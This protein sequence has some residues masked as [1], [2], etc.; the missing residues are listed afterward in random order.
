M[1]TGC[2]RCPSERGVATALLLILTLPALALAQSEPPPGMEPVELTDPLD[3][4]TFE[5]FVPMSTNGLG[6][7]D[8]DGCSYARG[9][10]P[11]NHEIVTSPT[12]LYSA[13]LDAWKLPV[14]AEQK[15]PLMETLLSL[16]RDVESVRSLTPADK[17]E[18]AAAVARQLGRDEFTIGQL[19]LSGAWTV[20]DTIVGFLPGIQGAGDAW[21]KLVETLP[22]VKELTEPR[23]RTI[24]LFDMAR[25][26][27]RG[28][29]VHERSDFMSLVG[30]VPDAGLGAAAK[31]AEFARRVAAE[32]RLLTKARDAFRA[33][34]DKPDGHPEDRARIRFLVGEITRRLGDFDEARTTLEGVE[35]DAVAGEETRALAR[36]VL[37]VLKVQASAPTVS[38]NTEGAPATPATTD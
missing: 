25:L 28:G 32:D 13:T 27:H 22:M 31:R 4:H 24:A 23:G 8:A 35:L 7:F 2:S 36:D 5:V 6:G 16:G 17:Y 3:G 15:G 12:T 29:F 21:S 9:E 37:A 19:Y 38:A 30:S 10:Q 14:S 34:L 11:R 20:R 26:S 1:R 18:L 33:G